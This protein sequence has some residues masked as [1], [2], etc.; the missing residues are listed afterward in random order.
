MRL[1]SLIKIYC[2]VIL[3]LLNGIILIV[4]LCSD[5]KVNCEQTR[6]RKS[7]VIL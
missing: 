5:C 6:I 4:E 7:V 2:K 1:K 3:R